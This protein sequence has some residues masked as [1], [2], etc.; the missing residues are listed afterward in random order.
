MSYLAD[1]FYIEKVADNL[2]KTKC[3]AK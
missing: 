2:Q 3:W 1:R